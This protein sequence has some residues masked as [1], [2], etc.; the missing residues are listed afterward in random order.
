MI[1][2]YYLKTTGNQRT[3]SACFFDK[4][5]TIEGGR[6]SEEPGIFYAQSSNLL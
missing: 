2:A 3:I 4:V 6:T 5:Y 1:V